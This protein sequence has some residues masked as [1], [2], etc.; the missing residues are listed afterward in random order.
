[1]ARAEFGSTERMKQ[2]MGAYFQALGVAA[3]DKSAPVAWCTSVGPAEL[4]RALGYQV[5]FPENHGAML[6][7]LRQANDYLPRAHALGY[8]PDICSY[9]CSDVGAYLAGRTPLERFGLETVPRADVLVFNTNQCHDVRHW[10]EFYGREWDVPVL[11]VTSFRDVDEVAPAMINAV[12]RQFEDLVPPLEEIAGTRLAGDRLE[13]ALELSAECT[14]LWKACLETAAH[15]PSPLSFFDGCIQ[16][17]PAVVLRGTREATEYYRLLLDEL[18][19]R[20][21]TGRGAVPDERFRLYWEGMPIW[22]KL[23]DLSGLF[24][25][26]STCVVASTYCNSWIFEALDSSDPF[27]SMA[28][29]SLELFIARAEGPKEQYIERMVEAFH[30][31]GLLFH[32]ARTCPNNSNARYG[33]PGRL[34]ERLKIPALT[35][36]GD[37][38]DLRCY[39]EEQSKT[40]IEG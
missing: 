12:A 8:S 3:R 36:D 16:M 1:M 25:R 17:G 7:A 15:R 6:G 30:L 40:S 4:L 26:L 39:S 13:A 18:T 9:L 32:D 11:G 22:G 35:I 28:R 20:V 29:A 37:L 19:E 38:N 14:R 23:R 10:F 24:E 33:M 34:R 31:D 5:Y 27:P 21:G 2:I